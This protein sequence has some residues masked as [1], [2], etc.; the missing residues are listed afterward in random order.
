M[1]LKVSDIKM[2]REASLLRMDKGA[3][4]CSLLKC[5]KLDDAP[6]SKEMEDEFSVFAGDPFQ[7]IDWSKLSFVKRESKK[8]CKVAFRHD[9]LQAWNLKLL[10]EAKEVW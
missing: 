5:P 2:L 6:M 9:V 3:E 4:G 1:K 8:V 10:A 7:L